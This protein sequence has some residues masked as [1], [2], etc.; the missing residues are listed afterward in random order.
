MN[1]RARAA[2]TV[3]AERG[4]ALLAVLLALTLLMLLALPFAVSMGAGAT[5]AQHDVEVAAVQ[6]GSASVR[7]LLLADAALSHPSLDLTPTHDGLDEFPG[8]VQLPEA[9]APLLE[10]GR[11]R[12]GGEV[13]D[14]QRYFGLDGAS[15]LVFAN[16]LGS[17]TRTAGDFDPE[18]SSL[19]V[20]DGSGLPEAGQVWVAGE[21]IRYAERR[22]NELTGLERLT[23]RESGAE[24][25]SDTVLAGAL[26]LDYRCVLAA[27]WPFLGHG[28]SCTVRTPWRSVGEL[29]TIGAAGHGTFTTAELERLARAFAAETRAIAAATWGRPERVFNQL[30]AGRAQTLQVRSAL[31][32]GPGSTVRLRDTR[33]GVTEYALVMASRTLRGNQQLL[34]PVV[35]ELD[36]LQPVKQSFAADDTLVEPLIPAPV[37]VNT[38][39][40]EV[41]VALLAEVR[42]GGQVRVGDPQGNQRKTRPFSRSQAR[43]L[44]ERWLALRSSGE[45]AGGDAGLSGPFRS[46][47]DLVQRGIEPTLA[48]A[49]SDQERFLWLSLYRNLRTGRDNQLEMGTAPLCFQSGPWVAYRAAASRSR[50]VVAGEVAARHERSGIAAA[51]PSAS[52]RQEWAT[53]EQFEE[54][55]VLDRRSPFW[56]TTPVNLGHPREDGEP[57]PRVVPHLVPIAYPQL[58]LGAARFAATDRT[59]AGAQPANASTPSVAWPQGPAGPVIRTS[60]DFD[61]APNLRG[62]DL[63]KANGYAMQNTGPS[64]GS[65]AGPGGGQAGGGQ[66]GGGQAGGG[67]AGSNGRHDQVRFPFSGLNGFTDRFAV[68]AWFEPPS[69][70]NG[71]L[72]DHGDGQ[73]NRNRL[74]LLVRDG[75]LVFECLDEAGLDPNPPAAGLRRN[76]VEWRVPLT[77]LSLPSDTPLHLSFSAYHGWP[78]DLSLSVDGMVRGRPRYVTYLTTDLPTF[79]P[80]LANNQGPPNAPGNE[81]FLDVPVESTEGF[82]AVGVL[83]IGLELFE[84]SSVQ[85]NSFRCRYVDSL[86]GRGARQ[87]GREHRPAVPTDSNGRPTVSIDDPSFNGVNLDFFPSHRSGSMVE[88]YGYAALPSDNSPIWR[89]LTQ[90]SGSIGAFAIA[91]GYVTNPKPIVVTLP[92]GQS[93]TVGRGIDLGWNGE[94]ELADP[95]PNAIG[96]TSYPP[97]QAQQQ[98]QDAFST[99]GG[100]ALLLQYSRRFTF[101]TP[102]QSSTVNIGGIEVIRYTSR[103]GNKLSGVMRQQTLQG[104]NAQIDTSIFDGT[105]RQFVC[106]WADWPLAGNPQATYDNV[107]TRI[108]FVV[109]ISLQVQDAAQLPNPARTGLTE[110]VQLYPRGAAVDTE[111]VRY[112]QVL[113]SFLLRANRGAWSN[114]HFQLTQQRQ[115]D[116][117]TISP[118]GPTNGFNDITVPPWGQVTATSGFIGYTPQLESL[119]PQ[120]L[121]A[122]QALAFRGDPFTGT[123]SH[124]QANS[125][126]MPCQRLQLNWGNYGAYTGRCGRLDRVALV[127]SMTARASGTTRPRVE[128]HTVHWVARRYG[129]DRLGNRNQT[130]S[131]FLGPWPFQLIAF[132]EPVTIDM[133]GPA[134]GV[135]VDDPRRFDRIVKFPSGELP[136]AYCAQPML[137]AGVDGSNGVQ[138]FVDEVEATRHVAA[139][140][141]LDTAIDASAR[142]FS[143]DRGYVAHAAGGLHYQNDRSLE[144]PEA[145]GLVDIDGEVIAYQARANGLFTIASNGRG[146][147][148]TKPRGHDRGARVRFLTHRPAA[149]LNRALSPRDAEIGLQGRGALPSRGT[150]LVGRT[151]LLHY[152]WARQNGN[153]L[154]LEMPRW[155]PADDSGSAQSRGLF[156]GRYGTAAQ[157]A[158]IGEVVI[159]FPF[160]YWDRWEEQSDDPELGYWQLTVDEA[161]LFFRHL[162]WRVQRADARVQPVVL[163]RYDALAPWSAVPDTGPGLRRASAGGSEAGL[164]PLGRQASRLEVRFAASYAA[165]SVDLTTLRAHAWKRS[166]R[167]EEV[168]VDYDGGTTVLAE[169]ETA[170]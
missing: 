64:A 85:G 41:L 153:Q 15:P 93:V 141:I 57:A 51:L 5:Q 38:A 77:D 13:I 58:G 43:E 145:G 156:R 144:Y 165:G 170:R 20:E 74:S 28:E 23:V 119:Y 104:I 166:L 105:A 147:L 22:G 31:H 97:A 11:V 21:R 67:Q 39:S 69:L 27:A 80:T 103:Q 72:F 106:D 50:S 135:Q 132:Q 88:L 167:I 79:D 33:S 19:L 46:W 60:Q 149:I 123:S 32:L 138:G 29:T 157:G 4:V 75:N 76:A 6:Q 142:Q 150:L 137:G 102:T 45:A 133:L 127:N 109:P 86:G 118:L 48:A 12:L 24:K 124:P 87:I 117:V 83:R 120:I 96:S 55:F 54:S 73:P 146:L 44:A 78:A 26:V 154:Q 10:G 16:V 151:E 62:F 100:Y 49:G 115:A 111:W 130:P 70:G 17:T 91:R 36:L 52:M 116:Q 3:R 95:V 82:P 65:G 18:A 162:R 113:D 59:D 114:L 98:I 108:L 160:R 14:L 169:Q 148:N 53:Q 107:P 89:G 81:R 47:Q 30:D 35:Y 34:L 37:N 9:F 163:V 61:T 7:D 112:D 164:F 143:V 139:D 42:Q 131:E 121:R 158:S 161:P 2:D 101:S 1:H 94:I 63:S 66:A 159:G 40:L 71:Y 92:S 134:E 155:Y 110:W 129:S 140:L 25:A 128:W 84:Y 125:L 68:S 122:R 168:A 90:P 126:V 8:G 152:A 56:V 136:S 99:S